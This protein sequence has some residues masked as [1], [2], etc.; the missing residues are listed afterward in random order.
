MPSPWLETDPLEQARAKIVEA[1]YFAYQTTSHWPN[2]AGIVETT[3]IQSAFFQNE[4]NFLGYDFILASE[5]YDVIYHEGVQKIAWHNWA[6]PETFQILE[7]SDFANQIAFEDAVNAGS[8]HK[9]SLKR[10]PFK[11]LG[12]SHDT[13]LENTTYRVYVMEHE[14]TELGYITREYVNL[15]PVTL[16]IDRYDRIVYD[17][18]G[19]I[20][21]HVRLLFADQQ[22]SSE[23][24]PF[25]YQPP[26]GYQTAYGQIER[27]IEPIRIGQMA[28]RFDAQDLEGNIINLAHYQG[29]RMMLFFS[30][31]TCGYCKQ[32][33]DYMN[34]D[35][36]EFRDDVVWLYLNPQ[37]SKDMLLKAQERLEVPFPVVP[38]P[39]AVGEA[40][41]V[42]SY[43]TFIEINGQG[44]VTQLQ[45]G[46]STEFLD[47]YRAE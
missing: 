32:S 7:P 40:F 5:R 20:D 35:G 8:W 36:Y 11:D 18:Q 1:E 42:V 4:E 39:K 12:Y 24:Q 16:L 13:V 44:Q 46:F 25:N 19:R 47:N 37:D 22:F 9:F 33:L 28:P 31:L 34:E 17:P 29:K 38:V 6:H 23:A 3:I 2:M 21:Q 10:L 45:G 41:G 30:T 27:E 14:P 15:D 26:A 43:P